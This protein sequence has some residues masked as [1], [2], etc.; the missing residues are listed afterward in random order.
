LASIVVQPEVTAVIVRHP[1][2]PPALGLLAIVAVVAAACG[3]SAASTA[4]S[5][6]TSTPAASP[7]ASIAGSASKSPTNSAGQSVAAVPSS[8]GLP[9][10]AHVYL[11]IL[12]NH[13][14]GSIVGSAS[15]P[16]INGLFARYGLATNYTGVS[17][18]SQPNY[19]AL[20]SGS[21][22]GIADDGVHTL[23]A[24][25]LVDQLET[26]GKTWNVFAQDYPGGCYAGTTSSGSGDGIGAA[27][28][29]ARKHDPAISFTD[30]ASNPARCARISSLAGFD[31][32]AGNFELIVPNDCNDMHSCSVATG[33]AFLK[34]FVPRIT[35]S[36][37]F[38][39]SVLFIT[40]DE[41][42]SDIGGGGRVATVVVSPLTPAGFTS[43]TAYSHYSILRTIEDAWGLGCL[44]K[45]CGATDMGAFF[46]SA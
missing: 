41:G 2:L 40:F 25:N 29:Y 5:T 44:G 33:D 36:P 30:I 28:S 34:T 6:A 27:G 3:G 42:T 1:L 18:P 21:T 35:G 17:H 8:T 4:M 10:F 23:S 19:I 32:A 43:A 46:K 26:K 38:A 22:Q 12:E 45:A 24:T 11:L 20:F 16:Y 9:D 39:D 31:P 7:S 13:E 37:A 15:A 14:A